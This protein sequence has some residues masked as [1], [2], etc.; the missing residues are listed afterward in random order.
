MPTQAEAPGELIDQKQPVNAVANPAAPAGYLEI[1]KVAG[2]NVNAGEP[3]Q[4]VLSGPNVQPLTTTVLAGG[5]SAPIAA[6]AGDVTVTETAQ[7]GVTVDQIS[8]VGPGSAASTFN[9]ANRVATVRVVEGPV[10]NVTIVNF[11]NRR[12]FGF[13]KVCKV[14]VT[15]GTATT[16][17]QSYAFTFGGAAAV[18]G[19][20]PESGFS[21]I[22][23][24][25]TEA[26][27]NCDIIGGSVN[28]TI[29]NAG[30]VVTITE[31]ASA[32][33][34]LSGVTFAGGTGSLS[35]NVASLTVGSGENVVT[36][37]NVPL[38][39]LQVCKVGVGIPVGTNF[40]F[41]VAGGTAF[42]VASNTL[43][44]LNCVQDGF[45]PAGTVVTVAEGTLPTLP[46]LTIALTGV[47]A[48]GPA[49]VANTNL[50]ARTTQV[51]IGATT[52]N[53][54]PNRVI[55]TNTGTSTVVPAQLQVCK[56][57]G[58]GIAA[59]STW[60]FGVS[61]NGGASTNV[62]AVAGGTCATIPGLA[63]GDIATVIEA[64]VANTQVSGI[65]ISAPGTGTVNLGT[66]T[67]VVTLGAG[68]NVV[69]YTNVAT[70]TVQLCKIA[71][72]AGAVGQTFTFTSNITGNTV[73]SL[74]AAAT[75]SGN[76]VQL[77]GPVA[78]GSTVTVTEAARVGYIV[79]G[80]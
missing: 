51:T 73:T 12:G 22:A 61:I 43:A 25:G 67:A 3:F 46:G 44:N 6:N 62:T 35:G 70:A 20:T 21:L 60:T 7:A 42:N 5:C 16:I 28:P 66:R 49:S 71:G 34:A 9:L 79:F 31:A 64:A 48:S 65:V 14:G 29:Y 39:P 41:T 10:N 18:S 72:N 56:V 27:S 45:Y 23:A 53:S 75:A 30:S 8:F 4:F 78:V 59:G 76:C 36:F 13:I 52:A 80:N 37:T 68:N 74:T 15:Q 47:A 32:N 50:A 1:C 63:Q 11:R 77:G 54:G 40:S 33:S 19:G 69:T 57:A 17:G 24:A 58:T 26:S 38:F 2:Q 55:F